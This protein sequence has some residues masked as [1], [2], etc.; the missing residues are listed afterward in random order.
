M[1]VCLCVILVHAH[2]AVCVRLLLQDCVLY[3][4]MFLLPAPAAAFGFDHTLTTGVISGL[5][6][7]IRRCGLC[8][9]TAGG[10]NLS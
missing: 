7:D 8:V 9:L 1:L 5:N 4:A 3:V 2:V 10:D 6:R